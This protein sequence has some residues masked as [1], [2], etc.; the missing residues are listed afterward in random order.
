M[1][2]LFKEFNWNNETAAK[3]EFHEWNALLTRNLSIKGIVYC[4]TEDQTSLYRPIDPGPEPSSSVDRREW[5]KFMNSYH[6]EMRKFHAN[7]DTAIGMLR[8]TLKY[9]SK[10]AADVEAALLPPSPFLQVIDPQA[11]APPVEPWTPERAFRAAYSKLTSAYAPRDSTDVS[12]IRRNLQD[13]SDTSSG[14]FH[15]YASEFVRLHLQLVNANATPTPTE[16]A[17]WVKHGIRNEDI[18]RLL[19]STI[20]I[21]N[22]DATYEVIFSTV[23]TYLKNL[24]DIDPYKSAIA[25]PT[26]KPLVTLAA[27]VVTP[28]RP[29]SGPQAPR[30]TKCWR[31]GHKFN[32][33]VAR[34]CSI[35]KTSIEGLDYCPKYKSHQERGTNFV[36]QFLL[37]KQHPASDT[38]VPVP[39]TETLTVKQARKALQVALAASKKQKLDKK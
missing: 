11:P 15:P 22:P 33:C 5:L 16:L 23:R 29:G 19:A 18:K 2:D 17:E 21:T 35:C 39:T 31:T 1:T 14:G 20:L 34:T 4:L 6:V 10:A 25:S 32:D 8:A 36:P 7:F 13:L 38:T 24:G 3:G 26:S 9:G 27:A 28:P 37:A 12:T 30:C